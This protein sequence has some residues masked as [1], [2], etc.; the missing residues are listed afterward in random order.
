MIRQIVAAVL[1][2]AGLAVFISLGVW[3]VHRLEWKTALLADIE[4]RIHAAPVALP[5]SPDPVRDRYLPVRLEGEMGSEELHVL[6]SSQD[7]GPGFRI[8]SPFTSDDGRRVLVDRGFVPDNQRDAKRPPGPTALTGN[9]YWPDDRDSFTPEDD[10]AGNWWYARDIG[11]MSA[12]LG[13]EPVL[14]VLRESSD[15]AVR[16]WPV[17]PEGIRNKHLEYA[18]TWF[19]LAATWVGMTGFALWRIRRR[20]KAAGAGT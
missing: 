18:I 15:S 6:V 9:L 14:V 3:Q 8:I 12:R 5:A 20:N 11:A 10:P 4:S 13:T 16:P 17:G 7:W 2:L 1:L 19:G